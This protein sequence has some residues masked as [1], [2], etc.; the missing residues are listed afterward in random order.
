MKIKWANTDTEAE[1]LMAH[2]Q[3]EQPK[4][5]FLYQRSCGCQR[6]LLCDFSGSTRVLGH[7]NRPHEAWNDAARQLS[8]ELRTS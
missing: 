4:Y 3:A 8:T 2:L 6:V 5:G 1:N 7:G